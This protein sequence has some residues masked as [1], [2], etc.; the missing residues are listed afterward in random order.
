[1]KQPAG[2]VV[3][4]KSTSVTQETI[5]Y[6]PWGN[7]LLKRICRDG[8]NDLYSFSRILLCSYKSVEEYLSNLA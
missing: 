4:A 5:R 6:H 1:M 7:N 8:P 2:K 3:E